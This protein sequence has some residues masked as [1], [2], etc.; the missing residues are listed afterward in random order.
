[1]KNSKGFTLIEVLGAIIIL[2][3][4]AIIGFNTFT[5]SLRGFR[6]DYYT[7]ISR[8][9]ENS[10]QEFFNDNRNYRPS[11]IL[12]AQKVSISALETKEYTETI[13]DYNGDKCENSSYVLIVKEG[14]NDYSYHT[15]LVCSEDNYDNTSDEYCD[16]A[17][18]DSTTITYGIGDVPTLYVYKGT[19]RDEV[20]EKLELPVSYIRKNSKG[21]VIRSVRGTGE[22]NLP[23]I[24]PTDIDTVDTNKIG[25]YKIHYE[26]KQIT[27][28]REDE[29]I[30]KKEGKVVVYENN[31]PNLNITYRD[32]VAKQGATLANVRNNVTEEKTGN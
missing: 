2:G 32:I 4:I 11:Q 5:S 1:M 22:D 15:C 25:T 3:I 31:A 12:G 6:E 29:T 10:G 24:L 28:G 27:N 8:S 26:F 17:W 21:E 9:L 20:K 30:E 18:L 19:S 7:E 13:V 14:R 23:T 16:S